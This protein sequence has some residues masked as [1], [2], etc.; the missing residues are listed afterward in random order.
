M[1]HLHALPGDGRQGGVGVGPGGRQRRGQRR[2]TEDPA[3][4]GVE[5]ARGV[6]PAGARMED[7]HPVDG[8]GRL[9]G[10]TQ[11]A[12]GGAGE[13]VVGVARGRHH[14]ADRG[15]G[16]V[17]RCRKAVEGPAGHRHEQLGRVAREEREHHL[18]L[19]IA[20]AHVVLNN[21]R[22]VG[23]QHEAGVEHAPV[24]D[25]PPVQG[26]HQGLHRRLHDGVD[27]PRR[28]VGHGSVGAH[29][30][31]VGTL[32]A[33]AHPLEV[34]RRQQ[35][36]REGAVV[37]D[38]QRA[39]LALEP[40]LYHDAAAGLPE[41]G[42]REL[43]L[44]VCPCL[45]QAVRHQDA[46]ASGQPVGLD[47]PRPGQAGQ[48]GHC[49][50][51]LGGAERGEARRGHAGLRQHLLHEGLGA[52]EAGAV[53][54]RAHD[55]APVGPQPVGQPVHQWCLGP[56]DHQVG[57]DLLGRLGGHDDRLGHARVA[58]RDHHLGGAS[59]HSGQRVLPSPAPHDTDL[60]AA[61]TFIG[62]RPPSLDTDLHW[63]R[64]FTGPNPPP[65]G[66]FTRW[67]RRRTA[68][69]PGRPRPGGPGRRSARRGTKRSCRRPR[70]R[71]TTR[72]RSSGRC[73]SPG[74]P[75]KWA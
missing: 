28:D 20:E 55:L 29:P 10:F 5:G 34:L 21:P 59:Q 18:G 64:T 23:P 49:V 52:F 4:R 3:A 30:P 22:T 51:E 40:L 67:R 74:A 41:G 27:L 31:R 65:V 37:Q 61:Q 47:H 24:D 39:L 69:G 44:H 50:L 35:G 75:R 62:C 16:R 33:V 68:R 13:G 43:G 36:H 9:A 42:T 19:G 32:V 70:A 1:A 71:P 53:G 54:A 15:V 72:W 57:V 8:G 73:A 58:R 7:G 2:H 25:A 6:G 48:V 38:E 12:D 17:G 60:H 66:A 56:D 46:L 26:G 45:R 63:A 11:P 14:D